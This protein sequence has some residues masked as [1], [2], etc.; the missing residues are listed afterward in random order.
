[1]SV[2]VDFLQRELQRTRVQ[3][4]MEENKTR[5]IIQRYDG[6]MEK[7]NESIKSCILPVDTLKGPI[8]FIDPMNNNYVDPQLRD[9]YSA[10]DYNPEIYLETIDTNFRWNRRDGMAIRRFRFYNDHRNEFRETIN[11]H[12]SYDNAL[13]FLEVYAVHNRN[14]NWVRKFPYFFDPISARVRVTKIV[15][16]RYFVS[17]NGF[18]CN[19]DDY[20]L[21]NEELK[22]RRKYILL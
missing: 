19:A 13:D 5:V 22:Y 20:L 9:P 15:G 3:R 10:R 7:F 17:D 12:L 4:R 18:I 6:D 2:N 21:E 16:T 8:E 14:D 1:M 11:K